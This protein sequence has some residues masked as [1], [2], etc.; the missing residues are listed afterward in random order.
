MA[1]Y[2]ISV[3]IEGELGGPIIQKWATT[4]FFTLLWLS[5][6]GLSAMKAYHII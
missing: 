2:L 1:A 6:L 5:Y 3:F 4:A